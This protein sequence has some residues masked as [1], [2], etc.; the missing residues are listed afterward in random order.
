M[1]ALDFNHPVYTVCGGVIHNGSCKVTHVLY[2][3]FPSTL[4]CA[5]YE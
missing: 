3:R 1:Y 5:L 4:F 2:A